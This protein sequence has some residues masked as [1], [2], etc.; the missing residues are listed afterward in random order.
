MRVWRDFSWVDEIISI[1]LALYKFMMEEGLQEEW[2]A[3]LNTITLKLTS[4]S[5]ERLLYSLCLC[6]HLV[7]EK[8]RLLRFLHTY[9]DSGGKFF[10]GNKVYFHL[11]FFGSNSSMSIEC[12]PGL[13]FRSS[14]LWMLEDLSSLEICLIGTLAGVDME[15]QGRLK[16]YLMC[17]RSCFLAGRTFSANSLFESTFGT[18][19][20]IGHFQNLQDH[21]KMNFLRLLCKTKSVSTTARNLLDTWTDSRTIKRDGWDL[22]GTAVIAG[23]IDMVHPL[24]NAGANAISALAYIFE[25]DCPDIANE[26]LLW[27]LVDNAKP[28]LLKGFLDPVESVLRN[29][30]GKII[31]SFIINIIGA[32]LARNIYLIGKLSKRPCNPY[33]FTENYIFL[34]INGD[35]PDILE[36]LLH[37]GGQADMKIADVC[38]VKYFKEDK[39]KDRSWLT[40][41]VTMGHT[42]CA[43]VL[44]KHG[45]NA[46]ALD[47][48]GMSAINLAKSYVDDPHPRINY[49]HFRRSS[50]KYSVSA[51]QDIKTLE[52][53]KRALHL[54]EE[55]LEG[56]ERNDTLSCEF[57]KCNKSLTFP[58]KATSN[59]R[60]ALQEWL[61]YILTPH[62]IKL[63]RSSIE[64]FKWNS[65]RLWNASFYETLLI[66]FFYVISY[67]MVFAM[68]I[69]AINRG[70]KRFSVPS[71][72]HLSMGAVLLLALIG[73]LSF[74]GQSSS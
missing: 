66:R 38:D 74:L 1:H 31:P 17:C 32:L 64:D 40:F 10:T 34:A 43:N 18:V 12:I 47:G 46:T 50:W 68:E 39:L 37:Y 72:S 73:G 60:A 59:L 41:S 70:Q 4:V 33:P 57:D 21:E 2:Y 29:R 45:A 51:E 58:T 53:L 44:I 8:D 62:Q 5:S 49:S 20:V 27:L 67:F 42:E 26:P 9:I 19:S 56:F 15:F 71:R 54:E 3:H 35:R 65:R 36:L 63:L 69:M 30:L 11:I 13:L 48:A 23:N 55:D 6:S 22:L 52:L 24:L 28:E 7:H 14:E 25:Y 16:E 61:C